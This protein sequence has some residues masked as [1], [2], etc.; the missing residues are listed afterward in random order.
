MLQSDFLVSYTASEGTASRSRA[1]APKPPPGAASRRYCC[2]LCVAEPRKETKSPA[3][4]CSVR[5]DSYRHFTP[6]FKASVLPQVRVV[7]G[8]VTQA[9]GKQAFWGWGRWIFQT[10]SILFSESN[11]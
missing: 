8:L 3:S 1:P 2:L 6:R 7:P 9:G 10:V 5:P 4:Q 11:L